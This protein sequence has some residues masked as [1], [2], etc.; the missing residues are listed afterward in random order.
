MFSTSSASLWRNANPGY[1]LELLRSFPA[2]VQLALGQ[3]GVIWATAAGALGLLC[4][5]LSFVVVAYSIHATEISHRHRRVSDLQALATAARQLLQPLVL[6]SLGTSSL[7]SDDAVLQAWSRFDRLVQQTCARVLGE[8][9]EEPL[10]KLCAKSDEMRAL[11]TPEM[12]R[13]AGEHRPVEPTVLAQ[14]ISIMSE[15]NPLAASITHDNEALFESLVAKYRTALLSL[16]ISTAGFVAAGFVLIMLV[17]RASMSFHDQ[18]RKAGEARDLLQETIDSVPAG[19]LVYDRQERLMMFNRAAFEST[20]L[21][22]GD[23]SIGMSYTEMASRTANLQSAFGVQFVNTPEEWIERFRSK[24]QRMQQVIEGRW[25]EW[26]EALTPSGR[27]VGLRVDVTDLKTQEAE[28]RRAR[29]EYQLLLN[30][31]QDVVFKLDPRKGDFTFISA[32]GERFFGESADR[33]I[34]SPFLDYVMPEDCEKVRQAARDDLRLQPRVNL[35]LF[36]M[37]TADGSFRHVESRVT[38]TLENG[39]PI[40]S[41]VIRDVQA[42]VELERQLAQETTHLRSVVESSGA[43]IVLVDRNLE[44]VMANREFASF[45]GIPQPLA[46]GRRLRSF[47]GCSQPG[48]V[49]DCLSGRITRPVHFSHELIDGEGRVR[50][51][52]ATMTPVLDT[53]GQVSHIVFVAFDDTDR[54]HAEQALFDAE[55]MVTVGEMA[56]TVAHE[57]SQPLQVIG[58]ACATMQDELSDAREQRVAPDIEFLGNKLE[59]VEAQLERARRIAMELRGFVR[60]TAAEAAVPF[61]PM[62]AVRGAIDMTSH[63]LRQQK[64]ELKSSIEG[65]LTPVTGH[66]SRLE[67]VLINLINNARDAG[68]KEIEVTAE[69]T[70]REGRDV[71]IIGVNDS[72]SGIPEDV[73]PRL[74]VSFI[75][76]KP[77]GVGTGLGLRICRRIIEEMGGAISAANRPQ[78]GARFEIVLPTCHL[79][80]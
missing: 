22:R 52:A 72:G 63:G 2:Q 55:R 8:E 27:T 51:Y 42:R 26:S 57:I 17:G 33:V 11:L 54:R 73:L 30:S 37:K 45:T 74:F 47:F 19:I 15:L 79:K 3:A 25:F 71:T 14:V 59:R 7:T 32:A 50:T 44:V 9:D 49:E 28:V 56:A 10:R 24:G 75:T 35:L 38:K 21:L 61:D 1:L 46:R 31:L 39:R 66:L 4:C 68:S 80:S 58:L 13:F 29:D 64:I 5:T 77:R 78:G 76:T 67:Q 60:G 23:D 70:V 6:T 41:G 36:R 18:W 20:P 34:G 43:L 40:L 12:T 65:P 62:E 69:Q 16:T 53:D 48:M